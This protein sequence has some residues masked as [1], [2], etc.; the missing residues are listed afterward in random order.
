VRP[1]SVRDLGRYVSFIAHVVRLAVAR[2]IFT[3]R[4][5][6]SRTPGSA[7]GGIHTEPPRPPESAFESP[8]LTFAASPRRGVSS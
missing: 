1:T 6:K 5:E 3:A 4:L 8:Q 7:C 2:A